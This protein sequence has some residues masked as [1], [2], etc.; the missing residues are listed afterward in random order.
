MGSTTLFC[1]LGDVTIQWDDANEKEVLAYIEKKLKEGVVFFL[2]ER[3]GLLRRK[4]LVPTKDLEAIKQA[5]LVRMADEND[6]LDTGKAVIQSVSKDD[7]G[8]SL[9][10]RLSDPQEIARSHTV[11]VAPIR[12]G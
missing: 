10:R 8:E 12:A 3:R 11:A 5:R 7:T 9:G 2:V 1:H 4:R 6:L